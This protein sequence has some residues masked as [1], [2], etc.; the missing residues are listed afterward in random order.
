MSNGA[1]VDQQS[2]PTYT[3]PSSIFQSPTA[4]YTLSLTVTDGLKQSASNNVSFEVDTSV[5]AKPPPQS[6]PPSPSSPPAQGPVAT[7][8]ASTPVLSRPTL[9]AVSYAP[10]LARF[11]TPTPGAVQPVTV[12][13][14]WRPNWFQTAQTAKTAGQPKAVKRADVSVDPAHAGNGQNATP[15]LAAL[16]AFGIFGFGWILFKRRRVRSALL[17]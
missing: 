15:E 10:Q 5:G 2:G 17:D 13:W 14:L 3:P 1:Q 4:T 9:N 7:P 8:G 12:I 11:A 6:P 16:A